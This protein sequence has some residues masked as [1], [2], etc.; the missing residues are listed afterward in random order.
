M[1]GGG[2]G[3][4]GGGTWWY[5]VVV[6]VVPV[7]V[8]VVPVAVVHGGA[9]GGGGGG[10]GAAAAAA[11]AG[12][13]PPP[14]YCRDAGLFCSFLPPRHLSSTLCCRWPSWCGHSCSFYPAASS[15]GMSCMCLVLTK[16]R[17]EKPVV[18]SGGYPHPTPSQIKIILVILR[19]KPLD[20][21][22]RPKSN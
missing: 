5:M 17:D 14:T 7:A 22:T 8:V 6:V 19:I 16:G 3:G 13:R 10:G 2:S 12:Y 21:I 20:Q 1:V 18:Q 9:G 11:A 4:G 15:F